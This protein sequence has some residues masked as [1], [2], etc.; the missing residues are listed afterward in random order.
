MCKYCNNDDYTTSDFILTGEI[1]ILPSMCRVNITPYLFIDSKN[2][3]KLDIGTDSGD[4]WSV[5]FKI[6]IS[7]CPMCGR[8]FADNYAPLMEH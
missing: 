7:Y 2:E 6:P 1:P 4:C 8:K 3:L 5:E